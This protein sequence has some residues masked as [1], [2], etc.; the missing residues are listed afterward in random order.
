MNKRLSV[1]IPGY[2]TPI[3][4]WRRCVK[5]VLAA[6]GPDDEVICV[7]D[8]STVPLE[9]IQLDDG[10]D[11]RLKLLVLEKNCGQAE[12]RNRGIKVM[13]GEYVT[14]VD[15]DDVVRNEVYRLAFQEISRSHPDILVFGI[16]TFWC[17]DGLWRRCVPP[18]CVMGA[19]DPRKALELQK[20]QLFENPVNK[21]FRTAFLQ[22]HN[23]CFP[24]GICPGEDT[25]FVLSCIKAGATWA[26]IQYSGYVYN[27]VDGTTLSRY[28]P[29]L[30][31]TLRYWNLAWGDYKNR[32][33]GAR[34]AFGNFGETSKEEMIRAEWANIWRRA[35]PYS[36][37]QRFIY[38]VQNKAVLGSPAWVVFAYK[39]VYTFLRL[40]VYARPIR[41]WHVKRLFPDAIE[42][43]Q[44]PFP[45]E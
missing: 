22:E 37:R 20:V 26:N 6:L 40:H 43:K 38:C 42:T 21:V 3:A 36:L 15:S 29:N 18:S 32:F 39:A 4:M 45:V 10:D 13:R 27:R 19:L 35:S 30:H 2:N 41:R 34:E 31:E 1:I 7:D 33:M 5:S 28:K 24:T 16:D 25:M 9:R 14:F 44:R 11:P 8:G 12:A 23:I 17:N